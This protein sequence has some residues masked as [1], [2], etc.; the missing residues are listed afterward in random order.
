L[1]L[2]IL[3]HFIFLIYLFEGLAL[4]VLFCLQY[5]FMENV[6]KKDNAQIA[7]TAKLR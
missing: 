1:L 7:I 6:W 2:F 3:F 5:I 4:D